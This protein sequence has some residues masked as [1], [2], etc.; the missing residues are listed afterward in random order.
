MTI[1][2]L[3]EN[4]VQLAAKFAADRSD[5][6]RRRSLDRA[7]FQAIADTGYLLLAIP[8]SAGGH[9]IGVEQSVRPICAALR[10]LAKG[11]SS[12]A[13]VS[14]MHPA[15]LSYWFGTRQVGQTPDDPG[16]QAW[17]AQCQWIC[18]TVRNGDWWGTITS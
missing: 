5:R 18:E 6:Q 17:D 12:V 2:Q 1:Q 16:Q 10:A 9:W 11:D 3:Q 4:V 14:A 8:E 13:L 15:V 7:D